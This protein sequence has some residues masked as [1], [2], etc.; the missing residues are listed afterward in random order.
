[1]IVK[2]CGFSDPDSIRQTALLKP[3]MMGFI[4]YAP[5][6]RN[7]CALLPSVVDELPADIDRTGVFVDAPVE[8]ILHTA[9]RYGL[10]TV[11]LHGKE[12][13]ETCRTLRDAGLRVM[14]AIGIDR[15][16]DWGTVAQYEGNVDLFVFDTLTAVHGGSG[17]KYDW[18]I[19]RDYQLSTPF[20]LSG[21]ITPADSAAVAEAAATLPH[22]AGVDINSRFETRPG[23][24]DP[25]LVRRF[26]SDL[27]WKFQ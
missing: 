27:G 12:T 17:R 16:I 21:G 2:I 23:C 3:S 19:L 22:M 5:S 6:P 9:S 4:F 8:H 26:L 11:Q 14:K 24:K 1:M 13:P 15:D 18:S 25:Q 10:S 7:A 20:L